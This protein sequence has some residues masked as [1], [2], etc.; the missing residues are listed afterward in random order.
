MDMEIVRVLLHSYR[1][2]ATLTFIFIDNIIHFIRTINSL[3]FPS[4]FLITQIL[5]Y[6]IHEIDNLIITFYALNIFFTHAIN[7]NFT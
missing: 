1:Y 4:Q 7:F 6:I 2:N 5:K 3:H